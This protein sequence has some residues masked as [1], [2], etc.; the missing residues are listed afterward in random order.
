MTVLILIKFPHSFPRIS[1]TRRPHALDLGK[2]EDT[3]L[4]W[5]TKK[6]YWSVFYIFCTDLGFPENG[7]TIV[8]HIDVEV[9]L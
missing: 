7:M 9:W 4:L 2:R 5:E 1:S 3:V 6:Y 8:C